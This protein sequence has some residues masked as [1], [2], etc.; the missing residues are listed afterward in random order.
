M[1]K[2]SLCGNWELIEL[3]ISANG[4]SFPEASAAT[5]LCT[6]SVPGDVS[7]D[8][9]HAGLLPDPMRGVNFRQ[10]DARVSGSSWWFRKT[11]DADVSLPESIS[12]THPAF[13]AML[14]LDGLDVEADIWLNGTFLGHQADAFFPFEMDVAHVLRQTANQL[15]VRLTTGEE[16]VKG[17]TDNPF[18]SCVP[19]EAGRGYP[20]RGIEQRI[21]LRKPAYVWGW[22]WSPR[23]PSCGITGICEIRYEGKTEFESIRLFTSL[24]P[25]GS[26][27]VRATVEIRHNTMLEGAS[28][29]LALELED[30]EGRRFASP[31]KPILVRSGVTFAE[32][33]VV[34]DTP[35]LWWPNGA[36]DQ[37]L[38]QVRAT[39][40][41]ASGQTLASDAFDWGLRTVRLEE[42]PGRLRFVVN[43]QP[44][45]IQGGNWV[46]PEHL[47]GTVTDRRLETLVDEAA[48]AHFNLL[49]IWG[50]GRF[51]RDAFFNACDR[52]GILLWHDFMSAC[53]PLPAD[54]PGF[55]ELFL[56]EVR[57]QVRRLGNHPS[58]A[59]WCGNNEV[60]ACYHWKREVFNKV[61]DPAWKL[62]FEEIPRIIQ[63]E[64]PDVPYWPTSPYG[65]ARPGPP[66]DMPA[67]TGDDHHWVVMKPEKEYWSCPEYWDQPSISIFN[68]EYG[69]GG[70]CSL[71]STREFLGLA[72]D[73][74]VPLRGDL[75]HEHTNTFY[76]VEHV[77]FGIQEHYGRDAETLEI[78]DYI[79]LG[80]LC[81]GLNLG[82]SLESMRANAQT[83]GA[84][85]WMYD[86]AW[87]ET[88]WTIVD[89]ALRRKISYYGVKRALRPQSLVWRLGGGAFGGKENQVLLIGLNGS[90]SEM[91]LPVKAGWINHDGSTDDALQEVLCRLAP[92]STKI[93]ATYPLPE[94][95]QRASGTYVAFFES[96]DGE[97][98]VFWRQG[99]Y[100]DTP[101]PTA[102]VRV[103]D[104]KTKGDDRLVW[105][106]TDKTAH[107]V[108]LGLDAD[109]RLSDCWFDL[110]PGQRKCVRIRGGAA[111][112]PESIIPDCVN[113]TQS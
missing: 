11:F 81:Q 48:E 36:G 55:T 24:S 76:T 44:I 109:L 27:E 16:R 79:R 82:Y 58:L 57:H 96:E 6:A 92:F 5:P 110:F 89:H 85:F 111:L 21:F 78:A 70:P 104:M 25:D 38:Y 22:D 87:G 64:S 112:K 108:S 99:R 42:E 59:M 13:R 72:N 86:D 75:A 73:E 41:L 40:A 102:T 23:L 80:G 37:P 12:V 52:R 84:I 60:G 68:S 33:A 50:G 35:M 56:Q 9:F 67:K 45:F 91:A 53:A 105:L 94:G 95:A 4:T 71:K 107:A 106:K 1:N 39:L 47:Y 51:E 103:L 43:G 7:A 30:E 10:A 69:Y 100:R 46:P 101:M 88:G 26:A 97:D 49:R 62:Y 31:A 90:G 113:G 20:E 29:T 14:S 77:S 61:R 19:T 3:P 66:S 2:Q 15:V 83:W 28:A 93:L 98:A 18:L 8:L 17:I 65:C 74:P 63:Q 54:T 32:V 34:I